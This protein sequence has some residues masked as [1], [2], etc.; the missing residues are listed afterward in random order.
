MVC[1]VDLYEHISNAVDTIRTALQQYKSAIL[2]LWCIDRLYRAY[3]NIWAGHEN[4]TCPLPT[5]PT[6]LIEIVILML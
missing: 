6:V 4:H 5:F 2:S 3:G 1:P